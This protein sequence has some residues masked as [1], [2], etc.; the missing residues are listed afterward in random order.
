MTR[1][2]ANMEVEAFPVVH[3]IMHGRKMGK[4]LD[5]TSRG[6]RTCPVGLD[7]KYVITREC[8]TYAQSCTLTHVMHIHDRVT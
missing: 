5:E 2:S 4:T 3:V 6:I 7:H 8:S 1:T